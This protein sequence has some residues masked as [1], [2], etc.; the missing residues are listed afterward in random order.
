MN[1]EYWTLNTTNMLIEKC[2]DIYV[3]T[4]NMLKME[5]EILEIIR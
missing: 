5:R 3:W 2:R 1:I 4:L